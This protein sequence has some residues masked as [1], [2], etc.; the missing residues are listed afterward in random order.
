MPIYMSSIPISVKACQDWPWDPGV[1]RL[2]QSTYFM[3][4][5]RILF[6]G[7]V[8]MNLCWNYSQ[9]NIWLVKNIWT[10]HPYQ[11]RHL[12]QIIKA[13]DF[14]LA[15]VRKLDSTKESQVFLIWT[16]II[17]WSIL[18]RS[19]ATHLDCTKIL[20]TIC[21]D[22]TWNLTFWPWWLYMLRPI[23]LNCNLPSIWWCRYRIGNN[24]CI[25]ANS[26]DNTG[27]VKYSSVGILVALWPH[28]NRQPCLIFFVTYWIFLFLFIVFLLMYPPVL[29]STTQSGH[30]N[31]LFCQTTGFNLEYSSMQ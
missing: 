21:H 10:P 19:S 15:L 26:S 4:Y 22:P 18:L 14:K 12:Q 1:R 6:R 16:P 29:F 13:T 24:S 28:T 27:S 25:Q 8:I 3:S 2:V 30:A 23:F 17:F 11:K 9:H 5:C 20:R 7:M 31:S